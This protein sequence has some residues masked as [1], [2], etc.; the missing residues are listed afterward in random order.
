MTKG[1]KMKIDCSI[2]L[3]RNTC[4][5]VTGKCPKHRTDFIALAV[6]IGLSI[7]ILSMY[8]SPYDKHISEIMKQHGVTR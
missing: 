6:L 8:V 3:E 4:D 2:C 5:G 7:F 1:I